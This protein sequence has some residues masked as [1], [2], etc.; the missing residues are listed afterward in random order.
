MRHHRPISVYSNL[1]GETKGIVVAKRGIGRDDDVRGRVRRQ[2]QQF[3]QRSRSR[4]GRH[5]TFTRGR[6]HSFSGNSAAIW[7][8][9]HL[10]IRLSC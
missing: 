7:P 8:C 6:D 2:R 9:S 3:D 1:G 5:T 4:R 10:E